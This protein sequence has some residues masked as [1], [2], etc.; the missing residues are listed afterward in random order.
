MLPTHVIGLTRTSPAGH[1]GAAG[2]GEHSGERCGGPQKPPRGISVSAQDP[3]HAC[4]NG[5]CRLL[6]HQISP[7]WGSSTHFRAPETSVTAP[8]HDTNQILER[9]YVSTY[10]NHF[11]T[12]HRSV[13]Y[14]RTSFSDYL[15]TWPT[16]GR[17]CA[18]GA[19]IM[20]DST[21]APRRRFPDFPGTLLCT[22][23][24]P[25]QSQPQKGWHRASYCCCD[26]AITII[27]ISIITHP[28]AL[29]LG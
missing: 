2:H 15:G 22:N 9:F 3:P 6:H 23:L 11:P 20:N 29:L 7:G 26:Y 16:L 19:I 12:E 27:T 17:K 14:I 1:G 8:S 13:V 21:S 18:C 5:V 24:C 25:Q 28:M 10:L 4:Y